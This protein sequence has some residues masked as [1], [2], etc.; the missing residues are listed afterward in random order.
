MRIS[1]GE[2]SPLDATLLPPNSKTGRARRFAPQTT[3]LSSSST[4][5]LLKVADIRLLRGKSLDSCISL[6]NTD[7]FPVLSRGVR[8]ELRGY[9]FEED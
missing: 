9:G 2:T 5:R 6:L 7:T 8:G 1:R 3:R 4:Q